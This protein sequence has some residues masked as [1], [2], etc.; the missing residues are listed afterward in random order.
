[1]PTP[2]AAWHCSLYDDEKGAV[3]PTAGIALANQCR[4][5]LY[6]PDLPGTNKWVYTGQR[7]PQSNWFQCRLRFDVVRRLYW[8]VL[9]TED[10]SSTESEAFRFQGTGA[11][12]ALQFLN[13]PPA[14]NHVVVD[15]IE[16]TYEDT[17]ADTASGRRNWA[18]EAT[19]E[20]PELKPV[21]DGNPRTG[22][23]LPASLPCRIELKTN[24]PVSL[25]RLHTGQ[26]G[27]EQ[28]IVTC[29]IQ[30]ENAAGQAPVLVSEEAPATAGQGYAEFAFPPEDLSALTFRFATDVHLREIEIYSPPVA[31]A[32]MRDA[33]FAKK[34]HGEFRLP[35]YE[36]QPMARLHL[37]NAD[38]HGDP[39]KVAVTLTERFT[40][41]TVAPARELELPPGETKVEFPI[42]D[43][44]DGAYI[45][46]VEDRTSRD[47][48]RIRRLLRIQHAVPAAKQASYEVSGAQLFFP[49]DHYLESL[50][51][52]R[53]RS[54]QGTVVQAVEPVTKSTDFTQL[55]R[56]VYFDRDGRLNVTFRRLDRRWMR[57]PE[58]RDFVATAKD[59]TLAEWTI[60]PLAGK[61]DM[62]P[63]G[64][65]VWDPEP[66]AAQGDW[67]AKRQDGKPVPLRFYDAD[68][69]GRIQISQI[70]MRRV[71]RSAKGTIM[72]YTDLDWSAI[73][74]L[75]GSVWPIWFKAPGV[76]L[77]LRRDSLLQE[78]PLIIG[79][80]E[81]PKA[82]NDNWA[83][84]FLSDDGT[85]LT[86]IHANVL[87][88]FPPFN[89]PWDNLAR[90]ARILT[91]YR[92]TDGIH[93][94]R[95]HM[96]LPDE[97]D[98]PAS[99][100]YGAIIR[101]AAKG[102]GL[103]LAYLLRYRAYTQQID[104]VVSYSWDGVRWERFSGQP[105]LAPNGPHG[106]WSAGHVWPGHV[107]VQRDGKVYHVIHRMGGIY[108]FQSEVANSRTDEDIHQVTAAWMKEHYGPRQLEQ[109]PLFSQFGSW[110]EVARHT[111]ETGVGVGVL[112]YRKDGL[113]CVEA[114]GEEGEFL[115][116]P[117]TA[118]GT[119]TVNAEVDPGGRLRLELVDTAGNPLPNGTAVLQP[120][121]Y[122]DA[123]VAFDGRQR[124]PAGPF[125]I[126][127]TLTG[128]KLYTLG[129]IP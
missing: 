38:E 32:S 67:Q 122:L 128:T 92:T 20:R 10:G 114:E 29:H 120:G 90:C 82:A 116:L 28:R 9:V 19:P 49:D 85:T 34:V 45:A 97:T 26:E 43:L 123:T 57:E 108:H 56:H 105:P 77:V 70:A 76:G 63:Q 23:S 98:P 14:G 88:R 102:K 36:N 33:A 129:A 126:R 112:V 68:T 106:S 59:H 31:P 96:A 30:G 94:T 21:I 11:V 12:Q 89:A 110:E 66:P 51:G 72:E 55:G 6:N 52:L 47:G 101:R 115:T 61:P 125:R 44:P 15:D 62:P 2:L 84:Q 42:A 7:A 86:Y 95:S 109:C 8:L 71:S 25:I 13:V 46:T 16:L 91:V 83:G 117:L 64:T 80:M 65:P 124:L 41:E 107:A 111:R 104:T 75:G 73:E 4:L 5:R 100:H 24:C 127:A 39:Q 87:R 27:E 121:D 53:F 93:Y 3:P 60:R 78:A 58:D 74:P 99:Q 50:R 119:L 37:V 17:P 40:G 35:V 22:L 54:C 79:E 118:R 48:G 113:F 1:M 81:D 18:P 69:D 103:R